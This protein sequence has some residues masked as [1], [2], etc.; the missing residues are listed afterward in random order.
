MGQLASV[1][2]ALEVSKVVWVDDMF[3]IAPTTAVASNIDLAIAVVQHQKLNFLNLQD[4]SIEDPDIEA[5]AEQ[6]ELDADLAAR[7]SRFPTKSP[8]RA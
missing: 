6:F 1:V 2:R 4:I 3:A 5:I 8:E 7:A